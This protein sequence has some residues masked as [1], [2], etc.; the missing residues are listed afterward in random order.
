[1]AKDPIIAD[2]DKTIRDLRFENKQLQHALDKK[3][4]DEDTAAKI[5]QH[6]YGLAAHSP[7]KGP[8]WLMKAGPSGNRGAPMTIWSDWHRG[9]VVKPEEVGGLNIFNAKVHDL[10]VKRLVENTI[11]LAFNHMGRAESRYPGIVVCLGG[12]F[13]N[14][15]I[16]DDIVI[17]ADRS[18]QQNINEM[19]DLLRDAIDNIAAKFGNVY[20]PCVV[21][22]H[23]RSTLKARTKGKITTSHEW[24]I[25]TN[26][27]RCFKGSEHIKF[28]VSENTDV[29]F[30][31]FG[32]R[33]LLTH[34]DTL[35]VRGGDGIIGALGPIKRGTLK[36]ENSESQIGRHFDT[37]IMGHWHQYISLPGIIVNNSLKGYDEF[38]R[39]VLRAPYSRPSQAL[40]FT[41]PEHG[42]TFNLQ[43]YLEKAMTAHTN[44]DWVS[45]DQAK[46]GEQYVSPFKLR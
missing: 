26:L 42:I 12:D 33:Y 24:N 5:R 13:I 23:G 32:H 3:T 8:A 19:T 18:T 37:I 21:G 44:S 43:V 14:G 41:H 20:L 9:E 38:A 2:K 11:D 40:W 1:M 31:V 36:V 4:A 34:G 7:K 30:N 15:D 39:T 28:Q 10:R 27:E 25:Y 17:G 35:G 16:H 45:F 6:V 22:N 46:L 29:L